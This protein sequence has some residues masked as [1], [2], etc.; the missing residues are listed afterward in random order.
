MASNSSESKAPQPGSLQS[1]LARL[2]GMVQALK[3]TEEDLIPTWDAVES[4][5]VPAEETL[6]TAPAADNGPGVAALRP[7]PI[8]PEAVKRIEPSEAA[9][10]SPTSE[11]SEPASPQAELPSASA[12][13]LCPY[14][15]A[16]KLARSPIARTAV[17][18]SHRL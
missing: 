15:Q 1:M 6:S 8:P 3:A 10:A 5:A 9:P 11:P 2:R 13:Q 18:F 14:C 7:E 16:R 17:G 4:P 12:P